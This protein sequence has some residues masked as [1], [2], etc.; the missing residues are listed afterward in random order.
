MIW[1]RTVASQM[2]KATVESCQIQFIPY[3]M[4]SERSFRMIGNKSGYIFKGYMAIYTKEDLDNSEEVHDIIDDVLLKDEDFINSTIVMNKMTMKE[5][6]KSPPSRYTESQLVKTVT[7]IGIGRPGTTAGFISKIQDK[8]YV[9]MENTDGTPVQII[10]ISY[11]NSRDIQIESISETLNVGSENKRLVPTPLG[12][13]VNDFLEEN[14]PMMMNL[15]FTA[16]L[17][18][19]LTEIVNN[20]LDWMQ[21]L[22]KFWELL[23]P[24]IDKVMDKYEISSKTFENN[25]IICQ[26]KGNDV[27]YVK[28]K[29]GTFI[30]VAIDGKKLWIKAITKPKEKEAIKMIEDKLNRPIARVIKT[31]GKDYIVKESESGK[32]LQAIKGKKVK[33]LQLKDIDI[34]SLT[35][36]ECDRLTSKLFKSKSKRKY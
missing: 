13:L 8:D 18:N 29:A 24:Q 28:I 35:K 12:I 19:Q 20:K 21:V 27:E 6:T 22:Y 32:F 25:T 1:K 17:E 3:S 30:L 36:E 26:Y 7:Q 15:K 31:F 9:R 33:F 16:N 14:F 4:G 2:S 23:K 5:H 11:D 10:K 34:N